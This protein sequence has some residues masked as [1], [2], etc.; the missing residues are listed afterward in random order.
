MYKIPQSVGRLRLADG[1]APRFH[2]PSPYQAGTRSWGSNKFGSL[3]SCYI[4]CARRLA[5]GRDRACDGGAGRLP[6]GLAFQLA[7]R[8]P[9]RKSHRAYSSRIPRECCH[10]SANTSLRRKPYVSTYPH[11]RWHVTGF[12]M[13]LSIFPPQAFAKVFSRTRLRHFSPLDTSQNST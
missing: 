7:R 4:G 6:E 12:P 13:R 9:F 1:G 5:D 10:I 8:A 11:R 3:A 2:R